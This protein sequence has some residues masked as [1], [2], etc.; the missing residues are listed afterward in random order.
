MPVL[1]LGT[2]QL[3]DDTADTVKTALDMGYRLIDT[4]GD[5]GTQAGIAAALGSSDVDRQD[6][7]LVTKVE[8]DEDAYDATRDRL[9]ELD[10]ERVDLMLIHRPPP[11]GA[12][13][14]LWRGLQQARDDGLTVDIGVSNYSIEDM[15]ALI[16]TSGEVPAVNQ[17]EWSPF[18]WSQT[19][20]DYCN[21]H[22]I[23]IQAYSPL[24]RT[25]RL[26]DETLQEIAVHHDKTPA[27]VLIR[28][29]IQLGVVPLPKA[30]NLDHLRENLAVFDFEL[31]EEDMRRLEERNE[32]YSSLGGSLAYA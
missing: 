14:D 29:N 6:L 25:E 18:G 26:D 11:S 27:H 20:L 22:G 15:N 13:V 19:M 24:T 4:S 9:R 16:E 3:T 5:Y 28:W 32:H 8:E 7:Y 10:V 31:R 21:G 17:I 2:W 12:G 1:G 30:N 23:V